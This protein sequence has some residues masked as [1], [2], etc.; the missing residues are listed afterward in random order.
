MALFKRSN[1]SNSVLPEEVNQ[2]YQSQRRE[3]AGVAV[4]LGIVALIVTLLIGLGLFFGGRA[5]YNRL[6]DNNEPKK[7][8]TITESSKKNEDTKASDNQGSTPTTSTDSTNSSSQSS[9]PAASTPS[10]SATTPAPVSTPSTGDASTTTTP[11]TALPAT[12]DEGM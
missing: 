3:R 6:S 8:E 11:A 2:Y 5:L 10:T 9:S 7:V 12:G 1:K 4:I